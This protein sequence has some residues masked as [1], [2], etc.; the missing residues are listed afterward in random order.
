M[1]VGNDFVAQQA[2]S[3]GEAVAENG[4]ANVA[5]MHGLGH[6]GG[7][8]IDNNGAWLLGLAEE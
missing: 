4:G 7:A 2:K 3:A 8:E 1:I 5:D 6:V